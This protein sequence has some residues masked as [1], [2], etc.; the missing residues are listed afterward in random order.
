MDDPQVRPG[1]PGDRSQAAAE[2]LRAL[3]ERANE[4]LQGHQSRLG[5]IETQLSDRVRQLAEEYGASLGPATPPAADNPTVEEIAALRRQVVESDAQHQRFVDQL[6]AARRQLNDLQTQACA[7]CQKAA[8]ELTEANGELRQLREQLEE[9]ARQHGEDR[10]RHE[11]FVEQLAAARQAITVL[12][13]AAGETSS[14]LRTEL[15]DCRAAKAVAEEQLAAA[16]RD[17]AA[18][19]DLCEAETAR[20]A[21]LERET[22]AAQGESTTLAA[23]IKKL[24]RSL[25]ESRTQAAAAQ[26]QALKSQVAAE[27]AAERTAAAESELAS[28]RQDAEALR[29]E[30]TALSERAIS[31]SQQAASLDRDRGVTASQFEQLRQESE[32][33]RAQLAQANED[34]HAQ[35]ELLEADAAER[36]AAIE[37]ERAAVDEELQSRRELLDA[38]DLE[39]HQLRDALAGAD[40]DKLQ[41][42]LSLSQVESACREYQRR[43]DELESEADRQRAAAAA[44]ADA[45]QLREQL[46]AADAAAA[47]QAAAIAAAQATIAASRQELATLRE[48]TVPRAELNAAR[49][50]AEKAEARIAELQAAAVAAQAK[51]AAAEAETVALRV[52]L[53][54][55]AAHDELRQKCELALADLQKLKRENSGLREQLAERSEGSDDPSPELIAVRGERDELAARVSELE[56]EAAA[57]TSASG[58]V[59]QDREDLQRRFEM[60]VDD[61]RQ[62]K[63]ENAK[64]RERAAANEKS[65]AAAPAHGGGSGSSGG[66][67][68]ASQRARLMALLEEEDVSGPVDPGRVAERATVAATLEATDEAL[69]AKDLELAEL[70]AALESQCG[71][72]A[73]TATAAAHEEIL[74]AD[75]LIVAERQRLAALTTEW[76]SKLRQAELEFSVE[77]AKLA[78]DQAA[79]RERTFELKSASPPAAAGAPETED[80][81]KPRRRWLSALGLGED[82]EPK[83][84]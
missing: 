55:L 15:E 8:Q 9:S 24:E 56:A 62:L 17:L 49:Q 40:Q 81:S 2:K 4:A 6:S 35:R 47:D 57:S 31:L 79:V 25:A 38:A 50:G 76:E 80:T 64:L 11:K 52:E 21:A 33:L 65:R 37:S 14:E 71:A 3:R 59:D 48:A 75:A 61:V 44:S 41:L 30:V 46:E 36:L 13:H 54:T 20:V 70:R 78:R 67:D 83:K 12:Q 18:L 53:P 5:E 69:A 28:V 22:S 16:L 63:Q 10:E 39:L 19:H 42:T 51:L 7:N 45:P 27:G 84:R 32:Q 72:D 77:R 23:E 82:D 34:A 74:D 1:L 60:A 66:S 73:T 43:Q 68:W 26:E 29:V 58:G